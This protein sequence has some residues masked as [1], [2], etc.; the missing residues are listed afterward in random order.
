MSEFTPESVRLYA[1]HA[2]SN[3]DMS[4]VYVSMSGITLVNDRMSVWTATQDLFNGQLFSITNAITYVNA[5]GLS[6]GFTVRYVTKD[7][8]V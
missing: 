7:I 8:F 2:K 4:Q 3:L 5:H 1:K 6:V